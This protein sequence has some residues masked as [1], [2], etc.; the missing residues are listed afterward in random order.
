MWHK[1]FICSIWIF[2]NR[3]WYS[4][5][6]TKKLISKL[7]WIWSK[8]NS[9][10]KS[11]LKIQFLLKKEW[12]DIEF[13]FF[14]LISIQS[15]TDIENMIPLHALFIVL[16]VGSLQVYIIF[17][18]YFLISFYSHYISA[19]AR[20]YGKYDLLWPSWCITMYKMDEFDP[21]NWLYKY[22]YFIFDHFIKIHF[23]T[24]IINNK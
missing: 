18:Y 15:L 3:I 17:F 19:W 6:I 10:M 13:W 7:I 12:K 8:W 23:L 9:Q 20:H 2:S 1:N 4:W 21:S 22:D 14:F 5:F 11:I 16:V 24:I